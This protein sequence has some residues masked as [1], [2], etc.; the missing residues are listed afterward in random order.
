[1][2]RNELKRV[3]LHAFTSFRPIT[4]FIFLLAGISADGQTLN[5]AAD[6]A[7]VGNLE[8][9][10]ED[11]LRALGDALLARDNS[12]ADALAAQLVRDRSPGAPY[13][14]KSENLEK[15]REKFLALLALQPARP[16][17]AA[18]L[19]KVLAVELES[20]VSAFSAREIGRAWLVIAQI[21]EQ[22]LGDPTAAIVA[23]EKAAEY[24]AVQAASLASITRLS[25]Q[26]PQK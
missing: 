24:K 6:F 21:K 4:L 11:G 26:I 25:R 9:R 1:M 20:A 17:E 22:L 7:V 15:A 14:E 8:R 5:R 12:K 23:Y 10:K 3:I 16:R 18:E 19:G 2:V 13:D